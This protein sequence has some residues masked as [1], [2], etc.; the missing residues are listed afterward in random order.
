[1][2][3]WPHGKTCFGR[4]SCGH[5][6][7]L[8]RMHGTHMLPR[9][10]MRYPYPYTHRC[11]QAA[12]AIPVSPG[13]SPG[14]ALP[15][16]HL[17]RQPW[18]R[19]ACNGVGGRCRVHRAP[20]KLDQLPRQP[21]CALLL[22]PCAFW[23]RPSSPSPMRRTSRGCVCRASVRANLRTRC[24]HARRGHAWCA[25]CSAISLSW[26]YDNILYMSWYM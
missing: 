13:L 9:S 8:S 12:P 23:L 1:M 17:A 19:V 7:A 6:L 5:C 15:T 18:P 22:R 24:M 11:I 16:T 3:A 25:P 20:C 2:A 14:A 10:T 26:E 4:A 21:R